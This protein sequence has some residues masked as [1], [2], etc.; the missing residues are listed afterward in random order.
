M[1]FIHTIIGSI[2]MLFSILFLAI[3]FNLLWLALLALVLVPIFI[4]SIAKSNNFKAKTLYKFLISLLIISIVL[5][6]STSETSFSTI[7]TEG[8]KSTVSDANTDTLKE[9]QIR[10]EDEIS[11][12]AEVLKEDSPAD[13]NHSS[14]NSASEEAT[15]HFIDTGNSDSILIIQGDNSILIDG[16]DNDDG[17]NIVNYLKKYNVNSITYM[18]ATH[19]HADHIGG[20]DTIINNVKV[21]NLL[22]ANGSSDTKTY[23]DFITAASNKGLSPSVPLENA[24]FKLSDS[25]YIKILNSN[26]GSDA[27]EQSLVTLFVNGDDKSL[28]TGD[29][30]AETEGEI[31]DRLPKINLLK[32]AHHGSK[33]STTSAFLN[34]VNPEYAVLTVG[35]DNKYN[36]PHS[37]TMNKLKTANIEVHRTDECSNVIFKSSGSG[38]TTTCP[39]GSYSY[40]D[41]NSSTTKDSSSNN[42]EFNNSTSTNTDNK[43]IDS[44]TGNSSNDS[45][46]TKKF[47]WTPK[48]KS[49]HSSKTCPS[50]SRS[51]TINEGTLEESN[52]SDPCDRCN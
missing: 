18:I 37:E 48:G 20:L 13:E 31:L 29:I 49:Y 40:R 52:K 32:V 51:K 10:K 8:N 38:I 26:G 42:S 41:N 35:K 44:G 7:K 6:V 46:T 15:I 9:S 21:E 33:S 24:E 3:T 1:K 17:N 39:I 28:F 25:S 36:H 5:S 19:P 4:Y 45:S 12:E 11:K 30:E 22:V 16:A 43:P 34:K 27:N 50:L 2:L 14:S 23:K 47:Y